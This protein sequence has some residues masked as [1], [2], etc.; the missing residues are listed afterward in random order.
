LSTRKTEVVMV[1]EKEEYWIRTDGRDIDIESL[2][3]PKCV[4]LHKQRRIERWPMAPPESEHA[5][6]DD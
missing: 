2:I 5:V 1:T 3:I 6:E 4:E